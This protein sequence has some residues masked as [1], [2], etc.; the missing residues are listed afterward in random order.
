MNIIGN[1]ADIL[2]P[3]F[4]KIF[5]QAYEQ[6][7]EQFSVVFNIDSSDRNNEKFST[8]TGFGMAKD[9]SEAEEI[10]LDDPVQGRWSK[11]CIKFP[12]INWEN[13][14]YNINI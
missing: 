10:P 6:Y 9:V 3:S 4:R 1:W 14:W 7:P 2:D 13:L 11:P 8:S 12:L 5:D